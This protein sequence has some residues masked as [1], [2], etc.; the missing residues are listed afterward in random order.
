ME[1]NTIFTQLI[2]LPAET[3]C[4]EFKEAKQNY[5][6]GKLGKYFSALSNEANLKGKPSA[7]LIF[8][9]KDKPI[10]RSIVGSDFRL[11]RADLDS[12][13]AEIANKTTNRI[14]FN[15][16]YVLNLTQGR[17]VMFD[18]PAA[19]KGFP[20][21]WEGHYY[22]R[23]GEDISPLNLVEIEQIRNQ[24]T[25]FDWSSQIIPQASIDDLDDK[26]IAEAK[27]NYKT[28]FPHLAQEVDDWQT[29]TFLNKAK[30]TI[31]GKITNTAIL[32][33]GKSE[34]E[35]FISPAQA[36]ITWILKDHKGDEIDYEHFDAPFLLTVNHVFSKIRNLK[37]RYLKNKSLFPQEVDMYD[38][39][40][41]REALHNCIAH[42]DYTLAGR[43]IV[44]E[45][46]KRLLFSN[47]GDFIPENVGEV[48]HRD[49]PDTYSRNKFLTNAMFNLNMIDTIGSGIKRMFNKQKDRYFPLPEYRIKKSTVSV[50]IHGE[51]L[52]LDYAHYLATH[53][54][55]TLDE[56]II[57]D[58]AQKGN[59][60]SDEENS[61]LKAI[62]FS[63]GS[64][65]ETLKSVQ[66]SVQQNRESVQQSPIDDILNK[67]KS[68]KVNNLIDLKKLSDELTTVEWRTL[69]NDIRTQV[70]VF[71]KTIFV[72]LEYCRTPKNREDILKTLNLINH[73]SNFRRHVQPLIDLDWIEKTNKENPKVK[74][75]KYTLT[76][77]G[78]QL[79][80]E[81]L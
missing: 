63:K 62:G 44:V 57:L 5:D 47:E 4:V 52:S 67:K 19:P 75:Q 26:A 11:N 1:L 22:G 78:I 43:V 17:V 34:S 68:L 80:G 51:I 2:N 24:A 40:V 61:F 9:V 53:K 6:F 39:Y 15:E 71:N 54:D 50:E 12:L 35:H 49:S 46:P 16:I 41:I 45:F 60:L 14:T 48:L 27:E 81:S 25:R 76:K 7:W 32:L 33:L 70:S 8:G 64:V 29:T 65:E 10:P 77:K 73:S 28:K 23:D 72:I 56:A 58:K 36:K 31:G 66:Q 21:A 69:I 18:I 55:T 42:Q 13:K 30:V 59:S 3:E 20:I 79:I 37:Y 38:A 74:N